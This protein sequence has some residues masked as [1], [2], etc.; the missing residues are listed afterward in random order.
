MT[1]AC[2]NS[3]AFHKF[4]KTSNNWKQVKVQRSESAHVPKGKDKIIVITL[5]T[6]DAMVCLCAFTL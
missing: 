4:A 5:S 6:T 1:I 2:V 3:R